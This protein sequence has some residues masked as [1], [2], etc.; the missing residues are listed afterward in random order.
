MVSPGREKQRRDSWAGVQA[1]ALALVSERGL[2]AVTV[3]DIAAA[4]GVSRRTFFNHFPT[5]AAALFDPHPDDADALEELLAGVDTSSGVW[6][7][8][9]S[10]CL[11]FV[12]GQDHV[13][14]VRR[15]LVGDPGLDAYHRTAHRHVGQAMDRWLAV[16]LP[17][18]PFA[19]RLVAETAGAVLMTAFLAWGPEEDPARFAELVARGFD[20]VARGFS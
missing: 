1:A 20:H 3:E 17:A 19:A 13:L 5:K 12:A 18:D 2:T 8:L 7:A 16:Q 4:A 15:R 10:V 6:T 9:R 14:A 11:E